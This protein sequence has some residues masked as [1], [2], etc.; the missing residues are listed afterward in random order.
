MLRSLYL[1]ENMIIKIDGLD[2]LQN[3]VVLNLSN[4]QISKIEGLDG[5]AKLETL[6]LKSN[7]IGINGLS[8]Y[9]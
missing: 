7:R 9:E 5:N 8:D 4:N 2:K 6:T 1:H 3:L